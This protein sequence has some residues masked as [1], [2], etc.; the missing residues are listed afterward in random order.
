MKI[1]GKRIVLGITGS[2]AAYK[3]IELL[4]AL[5]KKGAEVRVAVTPYAL[6]F[7]TPL[8]LEVLSGYSVYRE[9]VPESSPE[10]RH[11]TL[12]AWGE[13]FLVAPATAN[14]I[15]KIACGIAD[16]PVT[17]LALCFG[18]GIICPAMNV[19]MYENPIT[20]GNLKKLKEL[21]WEVVEPSSGYL[22]CGD[23]GKGRLAEIEDILDAVSYWFT[24]KLLKGKK[25]VVTAGATREYIDPVRFISN[26]SSG[27]MGFSIAKA[28]R[29][30][31]AEVTLITGNTHL[32]TPYGVKRIDVET[33]EEMKEAALSEFEK[34]DIYI[35]SAAI[36]DYRP[37]KR[38]PEKIK[39]GQERL[40]IE[41]ERTPDILKLIG[42]RKK[43]GQLV[44]GFAA[45]TKDLLKNA[46]EKLKKKNL[47][48]IVANDVKKG[49]FGS[50]QTEV[51]FIT[52]K[53][54]THLKGSKE[55][56]A[57]EIIRL[58]SEL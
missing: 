35:S 53:G 1:E 9:V 43:D 42:E 24:P 47:D 13:L 16:T 17:D 23:E 14:T 11:T 51:V 8:T 48:G 54:E 46:R 12:S 4:R 27:K 22:A 45:E 2:I 20:Q 55:D 50:D 31:G 3:T 29:A 40:V 57:L 19:K 6:K 7:V 36:G 39:K 34:A 32:R 26:P 18:R 30:A 49:I 5:K 15:A 38:A 58:I 28:A 41:L 25:V 56:V 10:I 21:G 33:V 52:E 37:L 44:V